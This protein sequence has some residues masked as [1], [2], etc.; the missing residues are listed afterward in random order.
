MTLFVYCICHCK[1]ELDTKKGKCF[2][3]V[4]TLFAIN[5]AYIIN[6]EKRKLAQMFSSHTNANL[7]EKRNKMN[8]LVCRRVGRSVQSHTKSVT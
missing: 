5:E 6:G 1:N 4:R 7:L 8:E 3:K 2:F